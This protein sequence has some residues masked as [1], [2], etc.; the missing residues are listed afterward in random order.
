MRHRRNPILSRIMDQGLEHPA[1]TAVAAMVSLLAADAFKLP[2]AYWAAITTIVVMQST[3]GAAVK[4]SA[5]RFA[6]T[7][8]GAAV[9]RDRARRSG[10][11]ADWHVLSTKRDCFRPGRVRA[12]LRLRRAEPRPACVPV[13]GDH[14]SDRP[15]GGAQRAC[16]GAGDS[17]VHR[18]VD[19]NCRGV[20]D[21]GG[22]AG[23]ATVPGAVIAVERR[24]SFGLRLG[25]RAGRTV[26]CE[27]RRLTP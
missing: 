23:T 8:L 10:R 16:V 26:L 3:L 19:W 1:R 11:R 4:I 5:Q 21:H 15:V 18:G 13:R 25:L 22:M 12:G 2:D 7:A 17:S 27:F 20:G 9:C 6:G 24:P 14:D